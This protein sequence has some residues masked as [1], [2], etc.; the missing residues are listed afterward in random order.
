[1]RD[2][3]TKFSLLLFIFL[4]T[5][6][7]SELNLKTEL[8]AALEGQQFLESII[9]RMDIKSCE[10]L[11]VRSNTA[12]N[13]ILN[14][15]KI[16]SPMKQILIL[17]KIVLSKNWTDSE[18]ITLKYGWHFNAKKYSVPCTVIFVIFNIY[19]EG[20]SEQ[21]SNL[22]FKRH[23]EMA[24]RDEDFYVFIKIYKKTPKDSTESKIIE[25]LKLPKTIFVLISPNKFKVQNLC[26]IC[27][28]TKKYRNIFIDDISKEGIFQKSLK[29]LHGRELKVSLITGV[30]SRVA[31]KKVAEERFVLERGVYKFVLLELEKRLNFTTLAFPSIGGGGSGNLLKNGSWNGAMGDVIDGRADIGFCAGQNWLRYQYTDMAGAMEFMVLS[32]ARGKPLPEFTWK[33]ALLP[34]S[35]EVWIGCG[36]SFL[37][38][39]S[40]MLILNDAKIWGIK[41]PSKNIVLLEFAI[42]AFFERPCE[43]V[44]NLNLRNFVTF[45][46]LMGLVM[47]TVYKGIVV[48]LLAFPFFT[49]APN[50]FDE[51]SASS[52][53]LWGLQ[54]YGGLAY[55]LFKY[56][57]NPTMQHL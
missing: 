42:S 56:S 52:K 9:T 57:S 44:G 46:S 38:G 19:T 37:L 5:L 8:K 7:G 22:I 2:I 6:Q 49:P 51:L 40:I 25:D 3:S 28:V 30:P 54:F 48:S 20:L 24:K 23:H 31:L 55:D 41:K 1:M 11:C 36:A 45:W 47:A 33:A 27:S 14:F 4:K 13:K 29:N 50:S 43:I 10:I 17:S 21:L 32:F 16:N 53:Y 18:E 12:E 26:M 34:F 35:L 15:D 39:F